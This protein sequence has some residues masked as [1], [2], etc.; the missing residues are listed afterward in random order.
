MR[1]SK[2]IY[3]NSSVVIDAEMQQLNQTDLRNRLRTGHIIHSIIGDLSA[4]SLHEF[5]QIENR[6]RFEALLDTLNHHARMQQRMTAG[7]QQNKP[8]PDPEPDQQK[9]K[10]NRKFGAMPG[11]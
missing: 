8:E 1:Y 11:V 5:L 7:Q 9:H 4:V 10:P 6:H 3:L 2:N